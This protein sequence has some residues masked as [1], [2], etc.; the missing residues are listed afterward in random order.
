[1]RLGLAAPA[2][3][4][5]HALK[6]DDFDPDYGGR[7]NAGSN[8]RGRVGTLLSPETYA[9][10]LARALNAGHAMSAPTNTLKK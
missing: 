1:M 8:K 7:W 3:F 9:A 2:G 5:L 4:S 10:N 6:T